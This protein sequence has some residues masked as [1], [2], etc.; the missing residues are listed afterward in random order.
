AASI[1]ALVNPIDVTTRKYAW[2]TNYLTADT[3]VAAT[4]IT[5]AYV[6]TLQPIFGGAQLTPTTVDPE[7]KDSY[8]DEY[9]LGAEQEIGAKVRAHV[10]LVRKRRHN[11]FGV[12]DRLR[13]SSSF[14][15]VPALDPGPDGSVRSADDRIITVWETAVPPVPPV[16]S[17]TNK[18]IGDTYSTIESGV[19]KRMSDR[20]QLASGFDWTKR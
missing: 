1:S 5:P 15:P 4:R 17:L 14:T 16:Y 9:T 8:T 19:T 11:T 10:A 13:T 12:Y 2:D 18:P 20:W 6:A 3:A 7:L